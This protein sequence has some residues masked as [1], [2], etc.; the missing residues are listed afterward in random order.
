MQECEIVIVIT[1]MLA[2]L[3]SFAYS[4]LSMNDHLIISDICKEG[5]AEV[6]EDSVYVCYCCLQVKSVSAGSSLVS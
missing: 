1:I 3:M 5:T 4:W 2:L 6:R